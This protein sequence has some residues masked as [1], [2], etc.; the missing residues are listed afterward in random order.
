MPEVRAGSPEAA[1]FDLCGEGGEWVAG[2]SDGWL[3]GGDV[4]AAGILQPE[5]S[6]LEFGGRLRVGFEAS[7]GEGSGGLWEVGW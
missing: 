6:G 1:V 3:R 2:A 4:R 7:G 5:L